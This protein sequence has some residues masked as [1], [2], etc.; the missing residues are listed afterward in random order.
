[1]NNVFAH[2][3][4]A[5]GLGRAVSFLGTL[6]LLLS[7]SACSP[8][9]P[10]VPVKNAPPVIANR[11]FLR[12]VHASSEGPAVRVK[13]DTTEMFGGS[14][15]SFMTFT[16]SNQAKYYPI[17]TATTTLTFTDAAGATVA[18]STLSL[19]RNWYY[20]AYLY[21]PQNGLKVLLTIDTIAP[22]SNTP[23]TPVKLRVVHLSPDAPNLTL[24]F[25]SSNAQPIAANVGYG[26]ASNYSLVRSYEFGSGTGMWINDAVSGDL[27]YNLAKGYVILPAGQTYTLVFSGKL[28]PSG[29]QRFLQ[30]GAFPES[31]FDSKDSL[32]GFAPFKSSLASIRFANLVP[33]LL[34]SHRLD[35]TFH[36]PAAEFANNNNYRRTLYTDR[37]FDFDAVRTL[38]ASAATERRP[39]KQFGYSVGKNLMYRIE[40]HQEL[41]YP[42]PFDYRIQDV[43]VAARSFLFSENG[44]F[45]IVAYGPWSDPGQPSLGASATLHDNTTQPPAG[46]AQVRLF[47]G[48]FGN[49]YQAMKLRLRIGGVSSPVGVSYGEATS[50]MNSF[51]VP[52]G[53]THIEV[54]DEANT[55]IHTQDLSVGLEMDRTYTI[56]FYRGASGTDLYL[57]PLAETIQ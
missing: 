3:G 54:I 13:G 43:F 28:Y 11:A 52:S 2:C 38:G 36:D 24:R 30:F 9:D 10:F 39:Y 47:H 45:T 6:V 32:Y 1:M 16:G 46:M 34:D 56:F 8:D 15:Q 14:L 33:S 4:L 49:P 17:D 22:P 26:T 37:K 35:V 18:S 53:T 20:S 41:K 19:R 40:Y 55:V 51:A 5:I 50:G 57:H 29:D 21:G 48:A 42:G 27:L 44:R 25:D 12:V 31:A 23:A 7:I